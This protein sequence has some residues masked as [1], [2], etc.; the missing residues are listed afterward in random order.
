MY[1]EVV[2]EKIKLYVK[3]LMDGKEGLTLYKE[4]KDNFP[5]ITREMIFDIFYNLLNSGSK[6]EDV[7][8]ILPKA[9]KIFIPFL[10]IPDYKD[11]PESNFLGILIRE[12][13]E[14]ISRLCNQR[15]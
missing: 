14:M 12:N 15:R 5:L 4:Y 3:G 8:L 9:V 13:R 2:Y 6:I 1:D 10:E 7:L 11:V